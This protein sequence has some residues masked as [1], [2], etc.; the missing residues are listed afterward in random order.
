MSTS[1]A[2]PQPPPPPE[3]PTLP[4]PRAPTPTPTRSRRASTARVLSGIRQPVP[5]RALRQLILAEAKLAR[6]EPA[7]LVWGVGLPVLL[8]VVFGRLPAFQ[9]PKSRFGDLLPLSVYL[10]ILIAMVLAMLAL[11]SLPGALAGYREQGVLRRM[12]TTPASPLLVLAAQLVV[13]LVLALVA[14]GLMLGIGAGVFGLSLPRQPVGFVLTLALTAPA[15]FSLGLCIAAVVPTWRVGQAVGGA[16]FFP[17]QFFAGLW[18]PR[19]VM[20][21][22]LRDVSD[23]TPLGAAVSALQDS[24]AGSFPTAK[25]LLVMAGYAVAFG[26]LAVRWFSWE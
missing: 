25:A 22:G 1:T 26:Y 8:L 21:A 18:V 3:R 23:F 15:L 17:L 9:Q 13:N 10:P 4:T 24:I 16:V 12:A 2:T 11:L 19:Q 14:L 6:R 5:P 20:P 7:G